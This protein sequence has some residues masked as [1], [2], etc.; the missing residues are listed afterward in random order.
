MY[1]HF[2]EQH[3]DMYYE[4]PANSSQQTMMLADKSVKGYFKLLRKWKKDNTTLNGK[5]NFPHY[6]DS[7]DGRQVV[8]FTINQA[9]LKEH[10]NGEQYI[11]FPRKANMEPINTNINEKDNLKQVRLVPHSSHYTIEVVY[12][13]DIT[14]ILQVD[15]QEHYLSIDIG[16]SNLA[17]MIDTKTKQPHYISGGPLKSTNQYYN[18]KKAEIQSKLKRN[19]DKSWSKRL[20]RMKL[21]R[22]NKINDYLHKKSRL[23]VDYCA[24]QEIGSIVIGKNKE[25]KQDINLG[26]QNNQNFSII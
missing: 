1:H 3:A 10:A 16:L 23:V 4:L 17:T 13:K 2:R 11:H 26:K 14:N 5:P 22:D 8:V 24:E 18:K 7:E 19:H 12:N 15:D 9:K 6:K 21:K 20:S 25:W